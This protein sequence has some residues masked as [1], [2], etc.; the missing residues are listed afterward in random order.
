VTI[1]APRRLRR[2]HLPWGV[3]GNR[4]SRALLGKSR[5]DDGHHQ[6]NSPTVLNGIALVTKMA[7]LAVTLQRLNGTAVSR[8]AW[9]AEAPPEAVQEFLHSH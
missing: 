8:A 6:P 1:G 3:E 7:E 9:F 4:P 2:H 5:D